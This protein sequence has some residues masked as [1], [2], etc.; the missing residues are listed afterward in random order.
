MSTPISGTIVEADGLKINLRNPFLAGV[1]AWLIPG[2]GHFYQK[3]YGKAGLYFFS[4][5]SLYI[6]GMVIGSCRVVYA[7]WDAEDRRWPY[8]CQVG[9]GLPA[10][11]AVWQAHLIRNNEQPWFG[12]FMAKPTSIDQIDDWHLE[13]A[14]GFDL[15]TLYTM[16]AGLLNVMVVF[17]AIGGPLPLPD[18]KKGKL[19]PD[20]ENPSNSDAKENKP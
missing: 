9:V 10:L 6:I 14:T 5:L 11:P 2:A 7:S 1:L 12:G 16:I 17:D 4:I 20:S 19:N 18:P 15:G 3:R 13:A 8:L